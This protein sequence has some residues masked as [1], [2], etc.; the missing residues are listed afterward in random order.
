MQAPGPHLLQFLNG[1]RTLG[2]LDFVGKQWREHGDVFQVRIGRRTLV[3]AMHPDVVE[4]VSVSHR[5]NYEKLGSYDSVR[6]YLIGNG[7]VASNG[8]LWRR[9]RKLMAPF[10]TPKGVQAY[11]ELMIRDGARLVER[12]EALASKGTEVEI[13]EEM[14]NVTA[15]IILKAMFSTETMESIHQMKDAV[16]TMLSF[17][18]DQMAGPTL[19]MWLPTSKNRKYLAAREMVHRSIRALIAER[20]GTDEAQWHDD[21]LSR[22]MKARDDETGQA[23]SESLLRDES[24]T[25]FFAGHETTARTMTFAWYALATNPKVT[26]RLHEELDRVLGGRTPTANELR[27]LPYTLQVIKEVLRLYPAAPFYARDVVT[28]D[29]FGDFDVAYLHREQLLAARKPP[30]PRDAR[31]AVHAAI[32]RRLRAALVDAGHARHHERAADGDH[33]ALKSAAH[34]RVLP[35]RR[36]GCRNALAH[37]LVSTSLVGLRHPPRAQ[38]AKA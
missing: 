15:S 4:R 31:A 36:H 22:L 25:T 6:K 8:E 26:E 28:A 16:E 23:M 34:A 35:S 19:P 7:I 10:Y 17:V 12:W 5:Q 13:A 3:F 1:V 2:F 38:R 21:L 33:A 18:N 14:T 29:K 11:A 37:R 32:A 27:Q 30:A 9:Q 24:I 20:R